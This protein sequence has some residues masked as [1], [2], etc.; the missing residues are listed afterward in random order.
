MLER[1]IEAHLVKRCKEIGALCEKFTSPARRNV[2]DRI[3]TYKGD[4]IFVELKATGEKPNEAQQRDHKRRHDAGAQ[5]VWTDS[6]EG[7][8]K[9]IENLVDGFVAGIVMPS[10]SSTPKFKVKV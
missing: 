7:V 5:V 10:K 2:P 3:V 9:I 1:D 4:V 6:K 8:E